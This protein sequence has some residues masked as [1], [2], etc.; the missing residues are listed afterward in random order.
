MKEFVILISIS[1]IFSAG[2]ALL[3]TL[4]ETRKPKKLYKI[5]YKERVQIMPIRSSAK[6]TARTPKSAVKKFYRDFG[7]NFDINN[8]VEVKA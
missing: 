6:I 7:P 5:E 8:V 1:V 2:I 3:A 4:L